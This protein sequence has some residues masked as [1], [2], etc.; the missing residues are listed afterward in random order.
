MLIAFLGFGVWA[1][2]MFAVGMGPVGDTV[3]G[4]TTMLI[5]IPTGVKIFNWIFT[6]WGGSIQFTAAM[7]F[8]I[9]MICLF[10]IGGISGVMHASPPAD[11]QQ[12]D[13]YFIVAHFH[14]VM[15]GGSMMGIFGGIYYYYPKITGRLLS[16][17]LGSWHIW[18]TFI[19]MNLTFF[20]M[21][22]SGLMGMPRRIYTYDA[23]QGWTRFNEISTAGAAILIVGT[24]FFV[25]NFIA[26]YRK[27]AV[28]GND[29][30]KAGTLE[31][32][33]PSPPPEYN[34]ARIPRV[35]SRLPLWDVTGKDSKQHA[36][37]SPYMEPATGKTAAEIGIP[38]PNPTI[39]PLLV[40]VGLTW[41]MTGLLFIPHDKV[42]LALAVIISGAIFMTA[43]L[44]GWVLSPLEDH[45]H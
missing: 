36:G 7:K 18:L 13:T 4:V 9:G 22:F 17:K 10:I 28:A 26:S 41:M 14:Y 25:W 5:A 27:G 16:E 19:G 44:Y 30:W 23:G 31:W 1:H 6:M 42:K 11:L 39:K 20:P 45:N 38:M 2:H 8:A 33:I 40:A 34:F 12:T 24:A 32:A 35:T 43:M 3:F 21:H 29:P 15:F 37:V